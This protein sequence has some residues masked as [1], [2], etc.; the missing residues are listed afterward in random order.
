M[1]GQIE[2]QTCI[3]SIFKSVQY[4][5]TNSDLHDSHFVVTWGKAYKLVQTAVSTWTLPHLLSNSSHLPGAVK[6]DKPDLKPKEQLEHS[7]HSDSIISHNILKP[8]NYSIWGYKGECFHGVTMILRKDKIIKISF[9]PMMSIESTSKQTAKKTKDFYANHHGLEK[10][11]CDRRLELSKK[12]SVTKFPC[13]KSM[14]FPIIQVSSILPQPKKNWWH[15]KAKKRPRDH[16]QL[17]L[18]LFPH[19]GN[20]SQRHV[21]WRVTDLPTSWLTRRMPGRC[22]FA[23]HLA[24]GT[25]IPCVSGISMATTTLGIL[26]KVCLPE[27]KSF[28][29]NRWFNQWVCQG[30][31]ARWLKNID[32][33]YHRVQWHVASNK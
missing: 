14:M 16:P 7:S 2:D 31:L 32:G 18:H 21:F 9:W 29:N 28:L 10:R 1:L 20:G 17:L 23:W 4:S 12:F 19:N 6:V 3:F 22:P 25:Q 33:P 27:M 8:W 5:C 26:W 15:R 13:Q 11:W 24:L 30:M